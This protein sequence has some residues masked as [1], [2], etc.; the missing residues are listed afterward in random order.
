MESSPSK[1]KVK[2]NQAESFDTME[3]SNFSS[4]VIVLIAK[5]VITA[6]VKFWRACTAGLLILMLSFWLY[7][8]WMCLSLLLIAVLGNS[9]TTCCGYRAVTL[10]N[11]TSIANSIQP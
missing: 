5:I 11:G 2:S 3:Q 10:V 6:F 4:S 7:G 9:L 1:S 8:S